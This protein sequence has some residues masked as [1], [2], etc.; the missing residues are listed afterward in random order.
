MHLIE[1]FIAVQKGQTPATNCQI[2]MSHTLALEVT[3]LASFCLLL[4]I[5]TKKQLL[6]WSKSATK[7]TQLSHDCVKN[8]TM[9][10]SQMQR[11]IEG[12][13]MTN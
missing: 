6:E 13:M 7:H 11:P 3:L 2:T 8:K 9:F 5:A 1:A 4:I 12:S 10:L